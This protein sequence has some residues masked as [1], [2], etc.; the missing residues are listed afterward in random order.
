M[1]TITKQRK[2]RLMAINGPFIAAPRELA[3]FILSS[4]KPD[5]NFAAPAKGTAGSD[6]EGKHSTFTT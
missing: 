4:D 5:P 3:V 6:T 2:K 1:G